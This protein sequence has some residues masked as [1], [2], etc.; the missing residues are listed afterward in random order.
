MQRMQ[1][2]P[3]HIGLAVFNALCMY[4]LLPAGLVGIAMW[5]EK[6]GI[7]VFN[8]VDLAKGLDIG[9][10]ILLLDLSMYM[11]HV[12][13]HRIPV[14]W[15]LHQVHHAD[16][17]LDVTSGLR[18]HPIE[19]ILSLAYKA[20]IVCL[21]GISPEV[22]LGFEI[23]LNANALFNH[24]NV[25]LPGWL[26]RCL[27]LFLVT[28]DMHRIHHSID[29]REYSHN[30]GFQ[31][32]WWDRLFATYQQSPKLGHIEMKVGLQSPNGQ[33][34]VAN[35]WLDLIKLPVYKKNNES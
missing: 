22:T 34:V 3:H 13:S 30:Y 14:L 17:D 29:Q 33:M 23:L 1:R 5:A 21:F 9:F 28:P 27:R 20:I 8:R 16:Q 11:Q 24:S 6:N 25:Y 12:L 19:A 18:F 35:T 31:L 26:D 4:L 2:W 7:G 10:G 32:T 15:R